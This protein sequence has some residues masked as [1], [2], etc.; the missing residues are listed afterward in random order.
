VTVSIPTEQ[1]HAHH[2]ATNAGDADLEDDNLVY[3]LFQHQI[4]NH[5]SNIEVPDVR[6]PLTEEQMRFLDLQLEIHHLP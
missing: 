2:D 5:L 3:N 1:I 4:P 6:C